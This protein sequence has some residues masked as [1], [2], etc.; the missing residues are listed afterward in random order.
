MR[1]HGTTISNR[2]RT[3][4]NDV[5]ANLE[6]TVGVAITTG[7]KVAATTTA[8]GATTVTTGLTGFVLYK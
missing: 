4:A 7:I 5:G 6:M 3:N 1:C 8:T 2:Q